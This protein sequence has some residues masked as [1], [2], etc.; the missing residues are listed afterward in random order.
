MGMLMTLGIAPSAHAAPLEGVTQRFLG[1]SAIKPMLQ[2]DLGGAPLS[3]EPISCTAGQP[4]DIGWIGIYIGALYR[5][6]IGLAAV[7]AVVMIMVGGFLWLISGGS[8]DKVG[9]AK[10][11]IGSALAGLLIALF[12]F[13]I[14]YTVNPRLVNLES[15][16][17]KAPDEFTAVANATVISGLGSDGIGPDWNKY[18]TEYGTVY[19][20][21]NEGFSA[22][23]Y[24][25]T[26][27]NW[28]IGFGHLME[29]DELRT[30]TR[31]EAVAYFRADYAEAQQSAV[32]FV[33]SQ[34]AFNGL[35]NGRQIVLTDM[36]YNLGGGGLNEFTNLRDAVR[37]SDWDRAGDEILDSEY[38]SQ[39]GTR[40]DRNAAIMFNGN[41]DVLVQ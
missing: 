15:L 38:A 21:R 5:F 7:L 35:S 40:A 41:M 1:T 4:C 11:F 31:D 9:R 13:I 24:Q 30:I 14:L 32:N 18:Y 39:V 26:G 8:P 10:E 33:G 37:N 17:I 20:P 19:T 23:A 3:F 6:G 2:V 16:Q 25:D 36:A 29:T 34:A 28:T 27:G 12:S 22:T